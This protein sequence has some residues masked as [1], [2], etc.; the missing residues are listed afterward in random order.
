MSL[1]NHLD[2]ATARMRQAALGIEAARGETPSLDSLRQWLE[3]LTAY[4]E[5]LADV[6][7]FNNESIHE[8]LHEIAGR[9]G[10]P[11]GPPPRPRGT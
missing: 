8:K 3:A 4:C 1:A 10:L 11:I 6:H 9:A 2:E 5:A 7:S